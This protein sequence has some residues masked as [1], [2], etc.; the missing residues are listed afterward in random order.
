MSVAYG[1][2]HADNAEGYTLFDC[3]EEGCMKS[4]I[5]ASNLHRHIAIGEWVVGNPTDISYKI[6]ILYVYSTS[7]KP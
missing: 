3:P 6:L 5:K 4:F 2:K 1:T 7:R